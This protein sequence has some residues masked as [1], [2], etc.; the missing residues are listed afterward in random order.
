[1]AEIGKRARNKENKFFTAQIL[2]RYLIET[3]QNAV[4][5]TI[6]DLYAYFG[7]TLTENE[8]RQLVY[9]IKYPT[10]SNWLRVSW[11][12]T[13]QRGVCKSGVSYKPRVY[14]IRLEP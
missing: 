4:K 5:I 1:M 3:H 6:H 13:K 10:R 2:E 8:K 9:G 7:E 12:R 14:H 11:D